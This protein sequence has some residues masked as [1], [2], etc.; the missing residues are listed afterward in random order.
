MPDYSK[1]IIYKLCCKNLDVK[2]IY[3][4]STCNFTRRKNAHKN[5]SKNPHKPM[6]NTKVYKFIRD[7]GGFENWDMILV[8]EYPCENKL[9]KTKRERYWCEELKSVLNSSVPSRTSKEYKREN[10]EKL[11]K[12]RN[13]HREKN[14]E[15]FNQIQKEYREKNND[16]LVE[17][18][19][20]HYAKHKE[21]YHHKYLEKKNELLT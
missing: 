5:D 10:K 4:G 2:Q 18:R 13:E 17:Y 12:Q 20:I 14:K 1:C 16:K 11:N 9:Q 15:K 3:V 6:Y 21:H 7:N 19:K 8:E